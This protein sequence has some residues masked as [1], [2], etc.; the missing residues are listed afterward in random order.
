MEAFFFGPQNQE[1]FANYHPP[2]GA[3]GE[4][5]TVICSPLF[6]EPARTYIALRRLALS[7]AEAGQHVLRFDYRGTGDSFGELEQATLSDWIED[8]AM[9]IRGAARS[10]VVPRSRF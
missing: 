9:A 7:I 3:D 8:I 4:I 6:S 2:F 10:P 5:L 1:L